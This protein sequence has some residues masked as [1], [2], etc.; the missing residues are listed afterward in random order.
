MAFRAHE[1]SQAQAK[2]PWCIKSNKGK[3]VQ[4]QSQSDAPLGRP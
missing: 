2:E 1:G 4:A 3:L